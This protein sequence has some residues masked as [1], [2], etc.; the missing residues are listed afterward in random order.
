MTTPLSADAEETRY[1]NCPV[2][3][4]ATRCWRVKSVDAKRY[5][6]ELCESC[7]FAFVNPRPSRN[8]LAEY[9]SSFGHGNS[10]DGNDF[11]TLESVLANEA[12]H[13]NSTIDARRMIDSIMSLHGQGQ[14]GKFLDV[15]CGYGFFSREARRGGFDVIP[16]E[17]ADN[18]AEIAKQLTGLT[19]VRRSFEDCECPPASISVVCMSQTLEHARD[20]NLWVRKSHD[21]L[22]PGGIIAIALPNFGSA[23]RLLLQ[24]NEPYICPPAHLNFFNPE[25]LSKL[26]ENHGFKVEEIQWVSRLPLSAFEK[27]LPT[28][29]KPLLPVIDALASATLKAID[30]LRLGMMINVYARRVPR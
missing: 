30:R 12:Q 7:G 6:L 20:I 28:V 24:E 11:P 27:R 4:G 25:S 5:P 15:G 9:Y 18:E 10:P 19:P 21:A 13:P 2:C 3:S 1:D 8:F 16:L 29:G 22:V 26:L 23:F 14:L 17:M